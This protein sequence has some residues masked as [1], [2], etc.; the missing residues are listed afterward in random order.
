M[1][2]NLLRN[3]IR[4]NGSMVSYFEVFGNGDVA[5][6]FRRAMLLSL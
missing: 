2:K 5:G 4:V 6:V 3:E 1:L